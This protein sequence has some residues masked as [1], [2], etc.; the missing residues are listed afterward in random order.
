MLGKALL[1]IL[2]LLGLDYARLAFEH[3][4]IQRRLTNVEGKLIPELLT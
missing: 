3:N 2:H 1:M 4:G